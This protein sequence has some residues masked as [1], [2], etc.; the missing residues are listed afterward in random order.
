MVAARRVLIIGGSM[1]GLFAGHFLRRAGWQAD[2]FE[3]TAGPLS[4]RGAGIMTHP[5]LRASLGVLGL[6]ASRDFGVAIETRAALDRDD[7][8]IAT[9]PFPQIATSWTKVYMLLAEA[10]PA[11]HYNSGAD[12]VRIEQTASG[13]TAH[14]ADGRSE[15][16]DVLVG[17]D[18]FRSTVR[19]IVFPDLTPEYAGYLAWRGMLPEAELAAP[20]VADLAS[21]F[22]FCLP[23]G[24]QML[25]YLVAGADNDLR[26]GKRNYNFVW[27]RPADISRELPAI[28][29]D[30]NGTLHEL[31]IPPHLIAP[32]VLAEMRAHAG[33]VLAPWFQMVVERTAQPFLQPIYDLAVPRMAAGRIALLGDAA[34]VVRPHVGGGVV[35]AAADA[36][37]LAAALANARDTVV[38][39]LQTFSDARAVVGHKMIAQARLLGS[40]LKYSYASEAERAAAAAMGSPEVVMRETALLHFLCDAN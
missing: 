9:R 4:A 15:T 21:M 31:S 35:K 19:R 39:A 18:G 5:E 11:A 29:T 14:F 23:P 25:G 6:E 13:V 12:L 17:A 40:Y 7:G 20:P 37:A 34:F 22:T 32:T 27:Y 1:A 16:G 2:I 28:L 38:Q 33:K 10:F 26:P 36:E 30:R 3:R 24:E 8:L